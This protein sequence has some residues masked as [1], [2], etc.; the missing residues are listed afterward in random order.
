M[1]VGAPKMVCSISCESPSSNSLCFGSDRSFTALASRNSFRYLPGTGR[2]SIWAHHADHE[3]MTHRPYSS[4]QQVLE[5]VVAGTCDDS[6]VQRTDRDSM[7]M[8]HKGNML[9]YFDPWRTDGIYSLQ[10]AS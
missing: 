5:A 10:N 1:A 3:R 2:G 9:L 4:R 8:L 6:H 7:F